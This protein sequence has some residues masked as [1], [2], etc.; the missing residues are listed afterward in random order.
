MERE[1]EW[2]GPTP[3]FSRDNVL[4]WNRAP[5]DDWMDGTFFKTDNNAGKLAH[6]DSATFDC[7]IQAEF[8]MK[9]TVTCHSMKW[10]SRFFSPPTSFAPFLS[11]SFSLPSFSSSFIPYPHFFVAINYQMNEEG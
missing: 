4:V 5:I 9:S 3:P 1:T 7:G 10:E 6:K 2:N 11:T 8:T